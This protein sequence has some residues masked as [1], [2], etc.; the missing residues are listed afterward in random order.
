MIFDLMRFDKKTTYLGIDFETESLNLNYS[1]PWQVGFTLFKN[2]QFLLQDNIHIH[3]DD[4]HI[5]A[6]AARI[7]HFNLDYHLSKAINNQKA[8]IKFEELLSNEEYTILGYNYLNFDVYQYN[9]WRRCLGLKPEYSH[10]KR[11]VDVHCLTK[12]YKL[13]IKPPNRQNEQEFMRFQYQMASL[14]KKGVK[15]SLKAISNEL[16]L[17]YDEEKAHEGLYDAIKTQEVFNQLIWK[18]DV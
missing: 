5:S 17:G 14:Y 2:G 10:L 15:T 13:G 18:L 7:T 8:L 1:R 16:N 3:W 6:E 11:T 12:A 4:L 9:T